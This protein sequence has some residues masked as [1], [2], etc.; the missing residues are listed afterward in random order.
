MR[1]G[2]SWNWPPLIEA[3]SDPAAYPYPVDKVE[4]RHT[5]ISVVLLA[6]PF[7]YKVKKPVNLG[8]LDF[9][10]LDGRRHFCEEEVRLNRRLAPDV[11]LGIVP[12]SRS[13]LGVK[14]EGQGEVV[15]WAVKMKRLPE[16]ATL[17]RRL[18]R[19]QVGVG[20]VKALARKVASF[21]ARA[22]ADE[23]ISAFG[24]FE[25]VSR[26]A[27]ENFEQ[28]APQV[29]AT[30][31]QAVFE[32][33]RRSTEEAL[34]RLRLLIE[35]RAE[36]GVPRDTHGDL[37]LDHVYLFPESTPPAD[38]VIIDCIEF[39]ERFRFADP[40]SDMAFL[41]MDLCFHRRRDLAGAFADEYFRAS[42]DEEGRA[43]LPFYVAY[44][45]AVRGKVEGFELLEKEIPEVERMAALAKA[46]AHWL[47]ALGELETPGRRPCLVLI[48]G[49]PGTGKSTL[50][51]GLAEQANFHLI[52]SDLV[53]KE[54]GGLPAQDS[55]CSAFEEGIYAAAWTERTY[56]EC[57]CRA[58]KLLSEG[59]RVIVDA[60]FGKEKR[61]QAFLN[62]AA[63]LAVP[64]VFMLCQV[65]A[66][67]ARRRLQCRRGDASDADWSVYR[68]ATE[69][70]ETI[71]PAIRG[72]LCEVPTSGTK[73]QALS[74]ALALLGE[75]A[76]LG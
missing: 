10:T 14:L 60:S 48:G 15:E 65:E 17:Q 29:G 63:Q 41:V 73:D 42:G 2:V 6:G 19:G 16:E 70:W 38:L 59:K 13:G 76:L 75:S 43:L 51:Q 71:G 36:R 11:Y 39:N 22:E 4:V 64:V 7:A 23:H 25:L 57:L 8:F 54:L 56:A 68:Q 35:S 5:H 66:E 44:R 26:N 55:A 46:R 18:Q 74:R 62:A 21:H 53:R 67:V 47:L 69:R 40:V 58:E 61:R 9:G 34:A 28:A 45:A 3:L 37:H 1:R 27:R 32:R 24:R 12:V 52:R 33:L 49:L 72:V 30:V 50:A 20:L 31:S